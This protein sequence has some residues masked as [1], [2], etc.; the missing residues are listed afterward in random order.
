LN[1]SVSSSV[2]QDV[3]VC[4]WTTPTVFPVKLCRWKWCFWPVGN[5]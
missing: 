4:F 2:V 5:V 1:H 3:S